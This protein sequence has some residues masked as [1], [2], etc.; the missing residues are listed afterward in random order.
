LPCF[1]IAF[2]YFILFF[3]HELY[4]YCRG[5]FKDPW[6]DVGLKDPWIDVGLK[7]PWIDVGLKE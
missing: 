3:T 1:Y 7:D 2:L 6:I 4:G 5:G